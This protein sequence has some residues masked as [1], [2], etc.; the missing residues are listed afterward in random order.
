[1]L[2]APPRKD[3]ATAW[4]GGVGNLLSAQMECHPDKGQGEQCAGGRGTGI[5]HSPCAGKTGRW[6]QMQVLYVED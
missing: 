6:L 4:P 3:I 2:N 5:Q 1:M